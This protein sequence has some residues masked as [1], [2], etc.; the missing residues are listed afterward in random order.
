[1]LKKDNKGAMTKADIAERIQGA[2]ELTKKESNEALEMVLSIMKSAL[3][4][5]EHGYS[6]ETDQ[7]D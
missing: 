7:R 1:M 3:E 5:G 4:Q 2:T 6:G